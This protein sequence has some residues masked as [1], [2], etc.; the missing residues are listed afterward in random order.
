MLDDTLIVWGG[1]FGRT[2]MQENRAGME[3]AWQGRDHHPSAFTIW[4][5]GGGVRPGFVHGE[6]DPIGYN[7]VS[8]P[9][10]VRDLHATL[11][12]LLGMDHKRLVYPFQG[13]DQKLTGVKQARVVTDVLA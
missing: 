9:V 10:Q 3:M 1:E 8:E 12:H 5:V 7:P 2:P 4:M 11:L 13:L 6:T